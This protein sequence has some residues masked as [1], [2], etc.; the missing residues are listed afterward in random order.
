HEYIMTALRTAEG[1]DLDHYTR[2][3]G[4]QETKALMD[5]LNQYQELTR[6]EGP[7]RL[8]VNRD[9]IQLTNEG[10]LFA[11]GIASFFF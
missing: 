5:R 6:K 2:Q 9:R 3:Y 11:D 10:K 8:V 4:L 1:L 7:E